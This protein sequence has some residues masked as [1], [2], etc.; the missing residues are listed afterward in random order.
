MNAS[1][2]LEQLKTLVDELD[3]QNMTVPIIVEGEMDEKAL[4]FLEIKGKIL[5]LHTGKSIL[6]FCEE[7]S[8]EYNE[9]IILTDWDKRGRKYYGILK[10]FL[11]ANDVKYIDSF[12]L[13]FKRNFGNEIQKVEE[14]VSY[15]THLQ[16][17]K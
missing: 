11:T 16:E 15:V 4:R 2:K 8:R 14:L 6:N 17:G 7:L 9:V 13:K 3:E 12:W 10:K 1:Q 5:R